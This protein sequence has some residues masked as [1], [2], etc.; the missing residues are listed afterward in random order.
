MIAWRARCGSWWYLAVAGECHETKKL[1]TS[2]LKQDFL[3]NCT[4]KLTKLQTANSPKEAIPVCCHLLDLQANYPK[5][6]LEEGDVGT[7][8]RIL[9]AADN[10][11][12]APPCF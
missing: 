8:L 7:P 5:L 6:L 11:P 12:G 10:Q 3:S 1:T 2:H 4:L 9:N